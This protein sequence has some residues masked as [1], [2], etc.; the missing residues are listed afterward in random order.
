MALETNELFASRDFS[1]RPRMVVLR[2]KVG[3]FATDASARKLVPGTPLAWNGSYWV[4]WAQGADAAVYTITANATPATAGS[5]LLVIEGKTAQ[6]AFDATAAQIQSELQALLGTPSVTAAA[7][8]GV[9]LGD[10]NAVVT[11]TFDENFGSGAP[12]IELDDSDLTGNPH[13]LAA[14][15]AG[16]DLLGA[17]KI[18]AFLAHQ[19]VQLSATDEVQGTIMLE[20][21]VHR[22]DINT[23]AI[24]AL[25]S[26][27][28][29]EAELDVAL[30]DQGLRD[31]S[32]H[33]RGL[34]S[35][36]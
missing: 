11:L 17:E 28:P 34:A 10:A 22:D 23:A 27:S 7:T 1:G 12:L 13:V 4:P 3:T 9:D 6:I 31:L 16:T 5:F 36:S 30:K 18:R 32:I 21:E 29:S 35:V 2:N 14:T 33:V 24:R 8:T 20:G 15:D 25:C 19:D 26:G